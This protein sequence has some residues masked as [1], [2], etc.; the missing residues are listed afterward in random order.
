MAAAPLVSHRQ[1]KR[2]GRAERSLRTVG[3]VQ[4]LDVGMELHVAAAYIRKDDHAPCFCL[5]TS[6]KGFFGTKC[7]LN[8]KY[9]PK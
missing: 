6:F 5:K 1:G 8:P 9:A 2:V 7:L 4:D 3:S